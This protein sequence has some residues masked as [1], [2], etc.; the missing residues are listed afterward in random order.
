MSLSLTTSKLLS[1]VIRANVSNGLTGE[2]VLKSSSTGAITKVKPRVIAGLTRL[3]QEK[4]AL[5]FLNAIWN[6]IKALVGFVG[7]LIK[8]IAFSATKIWQWTVN[9]INVLKSF[10]WN[11]TD[12]SLMQQMDGRNTALA[13]LWGGAIGQGF[14]WMVGIGVGYGISFLCPVIGGAALARTIA[15]KATKE[16]IEELLPYFRNVLMQTAGTVASNLLVS[17]FIQYRRLLKSAPRPLLD[18]IF[19]KDTA[20]FIKNVWGGEGGP[21]MSFNTQMDEA[22]ESIDNKYVRAFLEEFFDEAWDGFSEAGFIIAH[23][24]DEAYAQNR[25]SQKKLLGPERTFEVTPDVQAPDEVIKMADIPQKLAIPIVQQSINTHRLLYN[26]DVGEIIGQPYGD[27]LKARPQ[28]RQ[29]TILFYSRP[30]PPW[31][32]RNGKYCKKANYTIPDVKRGLTWEEIK[33]AVPPFTWGKFRATANLDNQRQMAVYGATEAEA[34]KVL[35]K[36][37]QLSDAK[38]LTLS[39]SEE[40]IRPQK[41][42]KEP[43]M[44]FPAYGTFLARRNTL[45]GKGRTTIDSRT[46][47]EEVIRFPLWGQKEPSGL[48]L[49]K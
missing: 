23:E 42:K 4:G 29:L 2:N 28:M 22:I 26:R 17:G 19:G 47:D 33:R 3:T 11:A 25:E 5:G 32:G 1:R 15:G 36:L 49:P 44:M 30:N 38:I 20:G 27:W 35:L 37:A 43:T 31:R 8:G 45:D 48:I 12:T 10:N 34:K 24:I 21:D 14:G 18:K 6:P 16:A 41:L 9:A 40:E 13:G 7:G 39:I 46:Y